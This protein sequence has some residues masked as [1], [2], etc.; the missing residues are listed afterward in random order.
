MRRAEAL[1]RGLEALDLSL[2]EP[3]QAKLLAYVELI[4]KWNRVY[5]LTAVREPDRML[6]HHVLDSLAVVPHLK[7]A[8]IVDVGSGAGL[9][10]VPLAIADARWHVVLLEA[11]HK[12]ASFLTQALIELDLPNAEVAHARVEAWEMPRRY[13]AVISRAFS[14]LPE[15]V[16]LA[17]RLCAADGELY[18]MK[19][20]HPFEEIAQLPAGF[21]LARVIPLRVPGI[22]AERH[23]VIIQ[24]SEEG[25]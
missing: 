6:S 4:E 17:G 10:G 25:K 14:D 5:N 23:L 20:I 2:A 7:G 18:A 16:S 19:G 1:A 8:H 21:R 22:D 12:K 24:P 11:N 13:D 3:A 9:P 15:F